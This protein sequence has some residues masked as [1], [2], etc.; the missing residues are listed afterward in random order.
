[1]NF[2]FKSKTN[3]LERSAG[4]NHFKRIVNILTRKDNKYME[5]EFETFAE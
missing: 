3:I 5:I 2:L 1:M 4:Y